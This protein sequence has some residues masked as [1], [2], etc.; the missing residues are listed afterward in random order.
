MTDLKEL[1][2]DI[3]NEMYAEAEPPLD[4]DEVLANPDDQPDDWYQRHYLASDEQQEIFTKHVDAFERELTSSE[5]A[6][7]S[8]TC[9][10]S[11]G[12]TG[13][14][15]LAEETRSQTP[16]KADNSTQ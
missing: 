10:T 1:R 8:L 5:H 6:D 14:K 12:P 7:L 13:N 3:L 11:L 16:S 2:D 9:I 4:F 15:E